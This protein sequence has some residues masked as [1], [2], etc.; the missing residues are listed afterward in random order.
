MHQ[1]THLAGVAVPG[2]DGCDQGGD[3]D[4]VRAGVGVVLVELH[5]VV[6]GEDNAD[7]VDSDPEKVDDVVSGRRNSSL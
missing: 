6:D 2:H 3:P 1:P 4:G 7:N 5:Q